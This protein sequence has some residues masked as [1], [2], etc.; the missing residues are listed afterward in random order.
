[1]VK[2]FLLMTLIVFAIACNTKVDDNASDE[3]PAAAAPTDSRSLEQQVHDTSRYFAGQTFS[4]LNGVLMQKIKE[5][6]PD[7]AVL[8]CNE[9]ALPLTD[10]VAKQH[11]ISIQRLAYRNRNP[12]NA[13][14]NEER[15]ILVGWEEA[16]KKN[17]ELK[18]KIVQ[19]ED[20]IDWYGAITIAHPRCLDCHGLLQEGDILNETLQ[21]IKKHYPNDKAVNF[22]LQDVRGMWKI[23]YPKSF[24]E[25]GV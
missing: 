25:K 4:A 14:S 17:Q 2:H 18:P 21:Q 8:F 1:M 22:E 16:A 13:A 23:S 3:S 15:N 5:V 12:L 6:G 10:S 9:R 11:G 20:K 19:S 7:G 24:F